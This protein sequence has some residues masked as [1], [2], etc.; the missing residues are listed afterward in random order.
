MVKQR[1]PSQPRGRSLD[2]PR[3]VPARFRALRLWV[4]QSVLSRRRPRTA[5][6]EGPCTATVSGKRPRR[7][8]VKRMRR[9]LSWHCLRA[10]RLMSAKRATSFRS[11][12]PRSAHSHPRRG[13]APVNSS[14]ASPSEHMSRFLPRPPSTCHAFSHDYF[15]NFSPALRVPMRP[16][17]TLPAITSSHSKCVS[18]FFIHALA[19]CATVERI[20]RSFGPGSE[21]LSFSC[22]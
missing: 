1:S 19:H 9:S 22:C 12:R 3:R 2:P 7:L 6:S 16:E 14:L 21:A 11:A 15:P 20:H 10:T 18:P 4:G 17:C 5:H 13:R 8:H